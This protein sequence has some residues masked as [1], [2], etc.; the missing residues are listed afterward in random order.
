M[1]LI[2]YR[3]NPVY[4]YTN[5][6]IKDNINRSIIIYIMTVG[7]VIKQMDFRMMGLIILSLTNNHTNNFVDPTTL[8]VLTSCRNVGIIKNWSTRNIDTAA[9]T[10]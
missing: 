10:A 2:G 4:T 5:K 7:V 1:V 9:G 3:D 8:L 6:A